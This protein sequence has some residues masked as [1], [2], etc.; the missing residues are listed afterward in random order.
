MHQ[1]Q[2]RSP[3]RA[4]LAALATSPLIWTGCSWT[5][6]HRS[7]GKRT[8]ARGFSTGTVR[9]LIDAGLAHR[10]HNTVRGTDWE[11]AMLTNARRNA[12]VLRLWQEG[13]KYREIAE[14][15]GLTRSTVSG[16]VHRAQE[17]GEVPWRRGKHQALKGDPVTR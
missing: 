8:R 6:L 13:L 5:Y 10:H 17:T 14:Q 15:V 7:P 3:H 9:D 11:K 1:R 4:A 12:E 16:I 2:L